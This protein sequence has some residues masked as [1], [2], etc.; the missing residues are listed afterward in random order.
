M[1]DAIDWSYQL[2]SHAER[3]VFQIGSLFVGG[4]TL[5]AFEALVKTQ[6]SVLHLDDLLAS[7]TD[8]H[9]VSVREDAPAQI[10]FEML[11]TIREYAYEQLVSSGQVESFQSAFAS[12][13]SDLAH[14]AASHLLGP[15]ASVWSDSIA[16]EYENIRAALRWALTHDR[17]VGLLIMLDL[18]YFWS[19][20]GYFAEAREWLDA[21]GDPRDVPVAATDPRMVW[22]VLNLRALSHQWVGD[23]EARRLFAEVLAVA[24]GL[25]DERLVA[26]SLNNLGAA[27]WR[28]GEY[29]PSRAVQEEALAMKLGQGDPWNIATSLSNLG[30]SLRSCGQYDL[31]LQRHRQALDLFRS[32]NDRWGEV[33]E[34]NDI[35]DVYRDQR[36]YALAARF[37]KASLDAN[38]SFRTLAADSFEG[39][40]VVAVSRNRFR[41]A[42]TLG[43]AAN[44][45]HRETGRSTALGERAAFDAACESSRLALSDDESSRAWTEGGSLSL[46]EA[47]EIGRVIASEGIDADVPLTLPND[48]EVRV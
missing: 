44:S 33:A 32:T 16:R 22:E 4:G 48:H 6:D 21:L 30:L 39:L 3:T 25:D 2:L 7:L 15:D 1:R 27:L 42:A 41:Q 34:L 24:R 47:I 45:V 12:Y 35:G 26:R 10:R 29:E 9:L 31:A 14:R 11:E 36:E 46:A 40:A 43:G 20:M 13:F 18:R 8:K 5:D 28:A 37:Y 19:R 23:H 38:S 17:S